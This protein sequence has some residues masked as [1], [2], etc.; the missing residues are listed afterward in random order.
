MP[1]TFLD[2]TVRES[3]PGGPW[4]HKFSLRIRLREDT[5]VWDVKTHILEQKEGYDP[6]G[7]RLYYLG[8]PMANCRTLAE[9]HVGNMGTLHIMR[10]AQGCVEAGKSCICATQLQHVLEKN[11]KSIAAK[12]EAEKKDQTEKL[13]MLVSASSREEALSRVLALQVESVVLLASSRSVHNTEAAVAAMG[14]AEKMLSLGADPTRGN[15]QDS[16]QQIMKRLITVLYPRFRKV[17]PMVGK[18]ASLLGVKPA[19]RRE[20]EYVVAAPLD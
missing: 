6:A 3:R 17:P 14:I 13:A 12:E 2:L 9:Y 16:P 18:L 8:V 11:R 7:A 20:D 15:G 5:L 19:R 4:G 1:A 10:G